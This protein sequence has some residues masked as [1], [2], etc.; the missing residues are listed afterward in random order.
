MR[1][2]Q[3]D[4]S[5]MGHRVAHLSGLG[6]VALLFACEAP[7]DHEAGVSQVNQALDGSTETLSVVVP[8][9]V[10][11][12]TRRVG[13]GISHDVY[14]SDRAAL[15]ST[16]RTWTPVTINTGSLRTEV[17]AEARVGS[18]NAYGDV[19][20]RSRSVVNG[21]VITTDDLIEQTDV[22]IAGVVVENRPIPDGVD[23]LRDFG[24]RATLPLSSSVA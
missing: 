9:P 17:G 15:R 12:D 16:N 11:T 2:Q 14:V 24:W 18:I 13:L 7:L 19:F 20:L 8:L 22:T 23:E 21:D 1:A 5:M 10:D 6:L 4:G 3:R